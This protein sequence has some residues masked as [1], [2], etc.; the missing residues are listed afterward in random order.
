MSPVPIFENHVFISYAHFD[1]EHAPEVGTGWIDRL[2]EG[3]E[4]RLQQLTGETVKIWRDPKLGGN[5]DFNSMIANELAK[6][7]LLV[8]VLTPRY[9]KS[10]SCMEE[11]DDFIEV[12]NQNQNL[13]IGNKYRIF[14]AIKTPVPLPEQPPKFREMLGYEFYVLNPTTNNFREY[15]YIVGPNNDRDKRFWDKVEDLA[16]EINGLLKEI[17]N[18]KTVQ[19][20]ATTIY[21]AETTLDLTQEREK[22]RRELQQNGHI[23]LPDKPLPTKG[24]ALKDA[25]RDYLAQSKLSIHMVGGLYDTIVGLQQKL[26]AE[27]GDDAE[28]SQFIWL[29]PGL[30]PLDTYQQ[31]FISDLKNGFSS[32]NGSELLETKLEDLKTIIEGKL[33]PTPQSAASEETADDEPSIYLMC[34][35]S[36]REAVK[37]LYNHLVLNEGLKVR[38]SLTEG[39]SST[40]RQ[41]RKDNLVRC[42]G[43]IVFYGNVGD[44]WWSTQLDE[45][46]KVRG[47][48]RTKPLSRAVYVA[49]PR[50]DEKEL[51]ESND[52]LII[53]GFE[54]F[55]PESL[56]EFISRVRQAKGGRP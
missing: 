25:V 4:I 39:D 30:E 40:I 35:K 36:D 52:P 31:Q 20:S 13:Q 12:A 49:A 8:S 48:G 34:D 1:N 15:D 17:A 54:S 51:L 44:Q 11:L 28:F 14:K 22:V 33:N 56:A 10:K 53:K 16:Q 50:T 5:D 38:L 32:K 41:D 19:P 27:R 23:V 46:R 18:K 43:V 24:Q 26:A 7:A 2:H 21:L 9:L 42:D 47:Y 37:A 29:P 45:L 55:K 3:L 6:T